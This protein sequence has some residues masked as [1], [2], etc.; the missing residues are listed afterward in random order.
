MG[1]G[2]FHP[3][4][5]VPAETCS[6]HLWRT[7]LDAKSLNRKTKQI[8]YLWK[9]TLSLFDE[10]SICH[11]HLLY[12]VAY[13]LVWSMLDVEQVL[14]YCWPTVCDAGQTLHRHW[15]NVSCLRGLGSQLQTWIIHST[16]GVTVHYYKYNPITCTQLVHV[17]HSDCFIF[18]TIMLCTR[19]AKSW[20]HSLKMCD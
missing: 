9:C 19:G 12:S 11:K 3:R 20:N 7:N 13:N 15:F 16:E 17:Q 2:Y 8:V 1:I 6:S 10:L 14:E 18:L 4:V 5:L